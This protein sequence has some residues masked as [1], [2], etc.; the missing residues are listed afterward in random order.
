M[1]FVDM[2]IYKASQRSLICLSQV[3]PANSCHFFK[4][5]QNLCYSGTTSCCAE[6]R[7]DI[8]VATVKYLRRMAKRP[9]VKTKVRMKNAYIIDAIRTPFGRYAGGLAPC[10]CR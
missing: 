5:N 4:S 2:K 8:H 6:Q 9:E 3:P 10:P 1:L 7:G